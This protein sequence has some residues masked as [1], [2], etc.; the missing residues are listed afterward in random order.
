V[1]LTPADRAA[2]LRQLERPPE[3][4]RRTPRHAPARPPLSVVT[5]SS[6]W[7]TLSAGSCVVPVGLR[8]NG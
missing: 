3:G 8:G 2:I 7:R 1:A 5:G 6:R 4:A